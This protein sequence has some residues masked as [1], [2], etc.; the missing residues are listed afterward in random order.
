MDTGSTKEVEAG[1]RDQNG[2]DGD[3]GSRQDLI[4]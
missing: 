3:D 2:E 1:D 4:G